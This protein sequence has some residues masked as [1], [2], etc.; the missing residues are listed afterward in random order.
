[1]VDFG[2]AGEGNAR[3]AME[4]DVTRFWELT[5]GTFGRVAAAMPV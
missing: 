1:V 5:L 4:I 3:V 2:L